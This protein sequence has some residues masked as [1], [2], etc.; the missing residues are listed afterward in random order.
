MGC[1]MKPS[2][3]AQRSAIVGLFAS[4]LF[5]CAAGAPDPSQSDDDDMDP[6]PP[7]VKLPPA[8]KDGSQTSPGCN[9]I[10]ESG[11]C[12]DGVAV[13]CDVEGDALR[14]KDCKALGKSCV[15]DAQMGALCTTA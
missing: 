10:P 13:Y 15:L 6:P 4:M 9:G 8:P 1:P 3:L 14:R 12:E 2:H 7:M 5:A 11:K